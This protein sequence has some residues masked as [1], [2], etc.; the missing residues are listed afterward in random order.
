MGSSVGG[1]GLFE[2]AYEPVMLF[3]QRFGQTIAKFCE[4]F[5]GVCQIEFPIIRTRPGKAH[6]GF[7]LRDGVRQA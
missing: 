2:P 4:E 3:A 6:E 1:H 7:R 5:A